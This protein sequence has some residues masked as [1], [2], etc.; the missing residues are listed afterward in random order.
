MSDC[1]VW[2]AASAV[3]TWLGAFATIVAVL[4]SLHQ[5][6][7]GFVPLLKA[8]L[9]YPHA[10]EPG[11][12][13]LFVSLT[14]TNVGVIDA[15]LDQL[16][17]FDLANKRR[18][19]LKLEKVCECKVLSGGSKIDGLKIPLTTLFPKEV[20]WSRHRIRRAANRFGGHPILLY[21][22]VE[23]GKEYK[24]KM[25]RK[26]GTAIWQYVCQMEASWTRGGDRASDADARSL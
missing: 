2:D 18:G 21:I 4:F 6:T 3:G 16:I 20:D 23:N 1:C 10:W 8:E 13:Q 11:E 19:S 9:V 12:N 14:I 25:R 17:L 7:K 26:E 24:V 22:T 15:R 5:S